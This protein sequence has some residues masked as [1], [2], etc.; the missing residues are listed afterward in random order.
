MGKNNNNGD[1][2]IGGG[3]NNSNNGQG[4]FDDMEEDGDSSDVLAMLGVLA[5]IKDGAGGA[6]DA[7][8][9]ALAEKPILVKVSNRRSFISCLTHH[10]PPLRIW[11]FFVVHFSVGVRCEGGS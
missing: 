6:W 2:M 8:N 3:N 11:W 1:G 5:S 9:N 4:S 7:Y 10:K